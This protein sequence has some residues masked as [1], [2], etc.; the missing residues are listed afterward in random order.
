MARHPYDLLFVQSSTGIGGAETVLLNL[1]EASPELRQRA[2]VATLGFGPGGLAARLRSVG[3]HVEEVAAAR[4]RKPWAFFKTVRRLSHLAR[5][6][7]AR[8]I[9][10][11]GCHPQ[12][13][14]SQVA[15][16][17]GARSVLFVHEIL[18]T[19]LLANGAIEVLSL[20]S[21]CDLMIANS[22]AAAA[23]LRALRPRIPCRVVY[24]GTPVR[25]V[26]AD[27]AAAARKEL[28]ATGA[29]ILFGMFGRFQRWKG[30]DVFLQ[31]AAR[32]AETLPAA[33]F[34]LVGDAAP[35]VE[36]EFAALASALVKDPRLA[37][38]ISV[39]GFRND[40][41]R[42]MAGCDVVCHASRTPEPFG[43]VVVEAMI[44]GRAVVATRGGGPS[45]ILEDRVSGCLVQPGSV[46]DMARAMLE[47]ARDSKLRRSLASAA[48]LR[49]A[50]AFTSTRMAETFL[51]CLNQV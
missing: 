1:F 25:P 38:R 29:D 33:R 30:Q 47:L 7:G 5:A 23:P 17:V 9:V 28:G 22:E 4:L 15:R 10:G 48:L 41:A 18:R 21:R 26:M 34:A 32:V 39:T 40:T 46:D 50:S 45:E 12:L 3:A 19:P 37:N 13:F 31:A 2:V 36:P 42:L 20:S 11:N 27:E 14:A 51:E 44:Q 35:G 16:R 6:T 49:A 24:P 8:T 43:M